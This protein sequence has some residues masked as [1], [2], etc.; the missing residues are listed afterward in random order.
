MPQ[1]RGEP[2]RVNQDEHPRPATTAEELAR[3]RPVFKKGGTVTAGN[4]SGINDGAAALLVMSAD[5][6]RALGLSPLARVVGTLVGPLQQRDGRRNPD[7][8]HHPLD[9]AHSRWPGVER[10][11]P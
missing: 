11:G 10:D 4:S 6:A 3:L 5:Q 9:G 8:V 1:G 7:A 2:L